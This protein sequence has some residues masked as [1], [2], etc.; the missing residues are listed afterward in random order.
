MNESFWMWPK[1]EAIIFC[2]FDE[3]LGPI[4][5]CSS[6][7]DIFGSDKTQLFSIITKYLLPDIHFAGKTISFVIG[8]KWRAI[9]VP[10]FIEGSQY[11]RN[12]FQFTVCIIV[13]KNPFNFYEEVYSRHIARTLGSAF[14]HLEE[15]CGI[16]YYYCTYTENLP[17]LLRK[18]VK[19]N[20]ISSLPKSILEII[21]NV[22]SQLNQKQQ[23]FFEFGNTSILSFR[24]RRPSCNI[25]INPEDVPFPYR[26]KMALDIKHVGL[27]FSFIKMLPYIN[28]VNTC[29]EISKYCSLPIEDVMVCLEHLSLYDLVVMIDMISFENRY[30][31][32]SYEED[33][34]CLYKKLSDEC[35]YAG[36][37]RSFTEKYHEELKRHNIKSIYKF[38]AK[39]VASKKITRL[40]EFP[41]IFTEPRAQCTE[42][43]RELLQLCNGNNTLDHVQVLFGFNTKSE[44]I[45]CI[46]RLFNSTSI[47][48]AYL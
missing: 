48:W 29:V 22:R 14:K 47:H 35:M 7:S 43:E 24:I 19:N 6:P 3:E 30:R 2:K 20:D 40:R 4:V 1:I 21:E 15:D 34:H 45:Q 13:E 39:G 18:V 17:D 27:D 32:T 26:K 11:L 37:V 5:L 42:A 28:G 38:I 44:I 23:V 41:I 46:N 25:V 31:Y 10:I 8:D 12:S 36:N 33:E 9:G 16:L